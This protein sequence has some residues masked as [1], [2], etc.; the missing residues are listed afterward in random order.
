MDN[1]NSIN[2]TATIAST[3]NVLAAATSQASFVPCVPIAVSTSLVAA[4]VLAK[5]LASTAPELAHLSFSNFT[6]IQLKKSELL[7]KTEEC[8]ASSKTLLDVCLLIVED[9]FSNLSAYLLVLGQVAE[10]SDN[11]KLHTDLQASLKQIH[12][13]ANSM[14]LAVADYCVDD[15]IYP[16]M[17]FDG[18]LKRIQLLQKQ[19]QDH[20]FQAIELSLQ[21]QK[22][23]VFGAVAA[24]LTEVCQHGLDNQITIEPMPSAQENALVA[25]ATFVDLP[26]AGEWPV[27]REKVNFLGSK[28]GSL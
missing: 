9:L 16:E 1:S 7:R 28:G 11:E 21:L 22:D 18:C 20:C 19:W 26:F 23:A 25:L 2:Q 14:N 6:N 24:C 3:T 5:R 10:T 13:Y 8:V 4:H 12:A 27:L 17:L 15:V